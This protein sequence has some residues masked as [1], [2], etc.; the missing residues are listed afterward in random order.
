MAALLLAAGSLGVAT[1]PPLMPGGAAAGDG[2]KQWGQLTFAAGSVMEKVDRNVRLT[3]S[4]PL[5][6]A[7]QQSGF[8]EDCKTFVDMPMLHDPE[9]VLEDFAKLPAE[10]SNRDLEEF[11]ER[12][13]EPAGVDLVHAEPIDFSA[14]PEFVKRIASPELREFAYYIHSIW[15]QLFRRVDPAVE[16]YQQRHTL[17]ALPYPVVVPG[18]RFRES[19]YWDSYWI[20]E[21]LLVSGMLTSA[22]GVIKNLLHYIE[23]FGFVPNG[24]RCYY[25]DR[26]QPP[27]LSEMVA[28]YYRH[29]G[30]AAL[31]RQALPLLDREYAFWMSGS[32]GRRG[33]AVTLTDGAGTEHVL[34][35]Y[36]SREA[37]PRPESYREDLELT[38]NL[39]GE[40]A[41]ALWRNIR[42]AAE[43]GWDF[44]S[45]WMADGKDLGTTDTCEIVPVGLNAILLRFEQNM[46][47]LYAALARADADAV[48]AGLDAAYHIKRYLAAAE[49][50]RA[51]IDAFLWWPQGAQWRDYHAK[52]ERQISWAGTSAANWLPLWA[53]CL[54]PD[55]PNLP[56]AIGALDAS[57][58]L[59]PAGV[60]TTTQESGQQWDAPNAWPPLQHMI[61]EG[62]Q[63]C[64]HP[65]GQQLAQ[66]LAAAWV[67]SNFVAWRRSGFMF[68]KYDA[69]RIGEGGGG[70][71]YTPQTGFGWSNGVVLKLLA[72]YGATLEFVEGG[73]DKDPRP[74]YNSR[75][76]QHRILDAWAGQDAYVLPKQLTPRQLAALDVD[77]IGEPSRRQRWLGNVPLVSQAL[78]VGANWAESREWRSFLGGL[79]EARVERA[80]RG[81]LPG[82]LGDAAATVRAAWAWVGGLRERRK[83]AAADRV[84]QAEEGKAKE[85]LRRL[86][87]RDALESAPRRGWLI[88]QGRPYTSS[89]RAFSPGT[90]GRLNWRDLS[91]RSG[92]RKGYAF[93]DLTRLAYGRMFKGE[94]ASVRKFKYAVLGADGVLQL[95]EPDEAPPGTDAPPVAPSTLT[96]SLDLSDPAGPMRMKL[97][98]AELRTLWGE[99]PDAGEVLYSVA[100]GADPSVAAAAVEAARAEVEKAAAELGVVEVDSDGRKLYTLTVS[101][102]ALDN[103]HPETWRLASHSREDAAEWATA[104]GLA[105]QRVDGSEEYDRS[106]FMDGETNNEMNKDAWRGGW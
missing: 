19:Y 37:R 46:A 68:E 56:R 47:T 71:E 18:G 13:F 9:E 41:E 28:T 76:A 42:A 1:T 50:R 15:P 54:P 87:L 94:A 17:L 79:R 103:E 24:G 83:A 12:N 36:T 30:D 55:D 78:A 27:M 95:Y 34:N 49:A 92:G 89:W 106:G 74:M 10:P 72:V 33:H 26:S 80:R 23:G 5:L 65:D 75:Y 62:L 73:R 81:G 99:T 102:A 45:R 96:S 104:L 39:S 3:T 7:I 98:G 64:G 82:V 59:Q 97:Q 21:G 6:R 16:M 29:T 66:V 44:S 35:V 51:A 43:S 90:L 14:D 38:E 2:V 61:I 60:Q 58:L 67:G 20:V 70:G 52:L 57:G 101:S 53:G 40:A 63:R 4:G 93:G 100:P 77:S 85:R 32:L 86:E 105:V 8:Y 84:K 22:R 11:I 69:T 88:C 91:G 48:Q 31:L 25:M